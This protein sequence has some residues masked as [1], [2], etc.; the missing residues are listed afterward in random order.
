MPRKL[1]DVERDVYQFLIDFLH[2]HTYQPS[3]RE[4]GKHFGIKSTKTVSQI[5]HA[6]ARKGYI[7]LDASRSRGVRLLGYAS[8]RAV[9]PVPLYDRFA[10]EGPVLR[11]ENRGQF[12]T[13]DRCF[14]PAPD[15]FFVRASDNAMAARGVMTGDLVLVRP[16]VP[17]IDGALV[18]ARQG[19]HAVIR[20]LMARGANKALVPATTGAPELPVREAGDGMLLGEVCGILRPPTPGTD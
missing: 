19:D 15:A 12:I 11:P 16:G 4:I 2:E 8:A 17:S 13:L 5:L 9:Q 20:A 6:I 18:A 1:T 3:V 14:L 7:E 10:R